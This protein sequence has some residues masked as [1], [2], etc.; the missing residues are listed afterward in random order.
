MPDKLK[1]CTSRNAD[2]SELFIVEGDSAGGTAVD[3]SGWSLTDDAAI[4]NKWLFPAGSSIG[5]GG[6]LI[7]LADNPTPE[8]ASISPVAGPLDGGTL[9]TIFGSGF[10]VPMQVWFGD[11]TAL[12]VNVFNDT[13]P[14]DQ[15]R[16]TCVT[17]DYSQQGQLPPIFVPVRVTNLQTGNNDTADQNFRYGDILYVGQANPTEGQIG[18]L[19]TLYGAGFEDPL[20]VWF[21]GDI[22]FDVISV[23]GTEITL[24]SP[25]DLP[26][27]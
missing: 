27:T 13:T 6:Y 5:A 16:I 1:D 25:P 11:L 7:V 3:I 8:I 9:V 19:L 17:P 21:A 23:T 14:A 12:D 22:E 2:E 18:D 4:P 15:D 26:P 20:T 10:Q 24:R